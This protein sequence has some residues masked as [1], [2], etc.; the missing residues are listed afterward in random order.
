MSTDNLRVLV[1]KIVAE[2]LN[3]LEKDSEFSE[4]LRKNQPIKKNQPQWA[5]TCS[6][7]RGQDAPDDKPNSAASSSSKRLYTE[8]DI[9]ELAKHGQKELIVDKKTL[10]TP[11]A[12]D[13][14]AMKGL[15]IKIMQ[16]TS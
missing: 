2:V 9:W 14:A 15:V 16:T 12:R 8:K 6:S 11:A 1:E 3:R 10:L 7:Y 13:A 5:R 4:L